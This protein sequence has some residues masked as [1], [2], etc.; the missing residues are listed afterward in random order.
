MSRIKEC[1]REVFAREGLDINENAIEQLAIYY[2]KLVAVNEVMNLTALTKPED[3]AQKHFTDS[4]MLLRYTDIPQDASVID[5]GTGAGF[6]GL[7]LKIARPDVQLTLLDSLNK[8]L[9]FLRELCEKLW[10][11]NVSFIHSRAE[12][13]AHT[14]LRE[15]YEIAVARAVAPLNVLCE[16]CLPYVQVGGHFIAMKGKSAKEEL[17]EAQNAIGLLGAEIGAEHYFTL[18]EAGER[19]IFEIAKTAFTD[20]RY[21][22]KSKQIKKKPL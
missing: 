2:E 11:E 3:V 19:A 15:S 20:P 16:Y 10:I 13:G 17:T 6:P 14:F 4:L 1:M 8:R 21:P 5:V 22:R 12:D 7:V 9:D 18:G